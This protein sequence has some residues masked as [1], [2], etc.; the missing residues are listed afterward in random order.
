MAVYVGSAR[1][2]EKGKAS[3]G[4]A[5]DQATE[6]ATQK[7]YKHEKGWRVFRAKDPAKAKKIA[8]AML[9]ACDNKKVGVFSHGGRNAAIKIPHSS[10]TVAMT[11]SESAAKTFFIQP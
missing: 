9:M 4:V 3:G 2:D 7:W 1:G 6:V 11:T 8:K 10:E 5:G